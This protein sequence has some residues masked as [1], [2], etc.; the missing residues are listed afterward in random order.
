MIMWSCEDRVA[1]FVDTFRR[2]A[3]RAGYDLRL[4]APDPAGHPAFAEMQRHYVHMSPNPALFELASFRRWFEI[5]RRVGPGDRFVLA[6]SDLVVQTPFDQLPNEIRDFDG[7]AASRG[8]AAGVSEQGINGGFS[9][10]SGR[11]LH[12]FCAFLV[13]TYAEGV[14]HLAAIYAAECAI[15]PRA[16]ISDMKLLYLWQQRERIPFLDT[17]RLFA[18][19]DGS[20][21]YIDHNFFMPEALDVAFVTTL[22]RKSIRF[23]PQGMRLQT[24]DGR[25]VIPASLHLGGR[26]KIMAADLEHRRRGTIA[27][28]SAYILAGRTARRLI[29]LSRP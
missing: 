28:K 27:A 29:A 23:T 15:N 26:Y 14:D 9:I 16:S 6:D 1:P 21:H 10:W 4:L 2:T 25:P 20:Q 18:A 12:D 8:A 22:G 11:L 5:A 17:N 13:A 3:T 7:L 24:R 19:T